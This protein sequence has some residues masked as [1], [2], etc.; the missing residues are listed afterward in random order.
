MT[1]MDNDTAI[2]T[3]AEMMLWKGQWFDGFDLTQMPEG[4]KFLGSGISRWAFL[5]PDG[6]VYKFGSRYANRNEVD[7]AQQL[8]PQQ[9]STLR[10]PWVEPVG[11]YGDFSVIRCEFM[12]GEWQDADDVNS[13]AVRDMWRDLSRFLSRFSIGD[14]HYGNVCFVDG[15]T[16]AVID[17]GW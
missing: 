16:P 6:W 8:F 13:R 17:L 3:I 14:V 9:D 2:L 10:I 1:R 11:D 7:A 5:A 15:G 4:W 12:D